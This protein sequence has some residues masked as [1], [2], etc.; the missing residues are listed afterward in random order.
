MKKFFVVAINLLL[1]GA[2]NHSFAGQRVGDFALIDYAGVFHQM[3][4]YNDQNAIVLFSL[5]VNA[6]LPSESLAMLEALQSNYESQGVVLFGINP[7]LQKDRKKVQADALERGINFPV[8]MDDAQLVSELLGLTQIG[9][10]VVYDPK[11]V[12]LLYRGAIGNQ[13]DE[14]LVR[15]LNNEQQELQTVTMAGS[16]IDYSSSSPSEVVSYTT[17]IAPLIAENCASCHREGGIGPW[18]MSSHL[19]GGVVREYFREDSTEDNRHT[20]ICL[21]PAQLI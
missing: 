2:M 21:D 13:I 18:N 5:G 1:I 20:E 6:E 7:G 12:E 17:D 8:L 15:H 16:V 11:K 19:L 10:V 14:V 4:W 9:E 3:S